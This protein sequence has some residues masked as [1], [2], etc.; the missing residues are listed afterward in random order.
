MRLQYLPP[1]RRLGIESVVWALRHPAPLIGG[2]A[3][4]LAGLALPATASTTPMSRPHRPVTVLT[5]AHS[6]PFPAMQLPPARLP[7]STD[8]ST[9]STSTTSSPPTTST[10]STTEA[11]SSGNSSRG[12]TAV[13]EAR[14]YVGTPYKSGGTSHS[15]IDCSGLTMMAWRAAGVS[16]PHSS[17]G[18]Y[19]VVQHVPLSQLQ[20]GD[21]VFYYSGPGHVAIY[22]G[23]GEVV[24]ALTYGKRAGV[25]SIDYAGDPVGAGRP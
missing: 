22:I 18:Q 11:G 24:E 19:H 8:S 20:P 4:S 21:L 13:N 15:G 14:T 23:K 7:E 2:L 17:S 16:L 12:Q 25:Y 9:S 1:G 5:T 6:S 10:T 3:L